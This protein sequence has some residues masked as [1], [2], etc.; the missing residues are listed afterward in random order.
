MLLA[1]T[2]DVPPTVVVYDEDA[3]Q[4]PYVASDASPPP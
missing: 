1:A 2:N 3:G 4:L